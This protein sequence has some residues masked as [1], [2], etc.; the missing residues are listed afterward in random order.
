[1]VELEK[2]V[3]PRFE[4]PEIK[5]PDSNANPAKWAYERIMKSIVEF[6]ARLDD[7]HE[8]GARLVN[9]GGY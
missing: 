2:L 7:D 1:M 5:L 4:I 6:E 3:V 9:F 8:I